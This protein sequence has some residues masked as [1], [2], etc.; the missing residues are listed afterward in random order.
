MKDYKAVWNN[1]SGTFADALSFVGYLDEDEEAIRSNGKQTTDFL[2]SVLQIESTD[3]VL[4]I[5]CG[6]TRIGR[7]LA[8]H[9]A[10]WHGSDIS[11]NMIQFARARTQDIPNIF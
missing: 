5:G 3:R 11:G 1:L 6:V 10:E 7:E 2:R 9:C 4:E 8:P